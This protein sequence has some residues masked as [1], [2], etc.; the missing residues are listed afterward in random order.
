MTTADR[1]EQELLDVWLDVKKHWPNAVAATVV[2]LLDQ[3]KGNYKYISN[4]FPIQ[5]KKKGQP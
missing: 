4:T 3:G 2:V 5:P 1:P